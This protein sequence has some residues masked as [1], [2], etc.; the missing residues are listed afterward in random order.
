M[1]LM[2]VVV[3]FVPLFKFNILV[4]TL[5]ILFAFVYLGSYYEPIKLLYFKLQPEEYGSSATDTET[6]CR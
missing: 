6:R 5:S 3:L 4:H 1:F 2:G